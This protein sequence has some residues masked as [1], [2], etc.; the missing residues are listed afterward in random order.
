MTDLRVMLVDDEE[1]FVTTLSERLHLRGIE[2]QTATD[3]KSALT[4]IEKDPPKVVV[5]DVLMPGLGGME[6][7]QRIRAKNPD[8]Q[9]ILLTGQ[10]SSKDGIEGMRLGAFDYL[11]KPLDIE[12]LIKKMREAAGDT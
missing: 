9:V 10:G 5:L 11:V 6:V 12:E 3:G 4:L 1:E 8:I 2:A 7:L